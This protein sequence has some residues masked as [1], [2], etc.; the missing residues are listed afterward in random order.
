[1]KERQFFW[2]WGYLCVIFFSLIQ[3][4]A[5]QRDILQ[6]IM[7]PVNWCREYVIWFEQLDYMGYPSGEVTFE[8]IV[9]MVA[10]MAGI[11]GC[12]IL[13]WGGIEQYRKIWDDIYKMVLISSISFSA[14]LGNMVREYLSLNLIFLI[15]LINMGAIFLRMYLSKKKNK[16]IL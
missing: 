2:D 9:S 6:L 15:F 8:R 4:G 1:M 5:F 7:L 3:N 11:V 16:F 10:I 14:V 13:V 12:V